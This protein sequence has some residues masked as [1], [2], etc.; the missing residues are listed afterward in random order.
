MKKYY[1]FYQLGNKLGLSKKDIRNIL[2]NPNIRIE[3]PCFSIGGPNY[4]GSYYGT[5]SIYDF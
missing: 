1:E 3:K 2:E 5:T 4:H